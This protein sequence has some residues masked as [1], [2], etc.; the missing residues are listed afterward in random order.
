MTDAYS[1]L[2]DAKP[3]CESVHLLYDTGYRVII[4]VVS[5]IP[6]DVVEWVR[7]GLD[8]HHGGASFSLPEGLELAPTI[9]RSWEYD[10]NNVTHLTKEVC[11]SDGQGSWNTRMEL[12]INQSWKFQKN[13]G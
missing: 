13:G 10:C 5:D 1:M 2:S 8:S 6:W 9:A 4:R 7:K 11:P 3:H 12:F